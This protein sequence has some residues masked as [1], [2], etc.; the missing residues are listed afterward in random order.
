MGC[1]DD[2]NRVLELGYQFWRD[3]GA[4]FYRWHAG[5]D[6]RLHPGN[7]SFR[8]EEAFGVLKPVAH[9]D[10]AELNIY[11]VAHLQ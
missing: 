3:K 7:F 5:S 8:W 4:D 11:S 1:F 10:F 6:F 9:S 2:V